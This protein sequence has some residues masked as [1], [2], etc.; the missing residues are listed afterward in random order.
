MSEKHIPEEYTDNRDNQ[1]KMVCSCGHS[2]PCPYFIPVEVKEALKKITPELDDMMVKEGLR[3]GKSLSEAE[4]WKK[5]SVDIGPAMK[6]WVK[7][8]EEKAKSNLSMP[9]DGQLYSFIDPDIHYHP[10][11]DEISLHGSFTADQLEA[12]AQ[13]MRKHSTDS[14][15]ES[16]PD[17]TQ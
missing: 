5:N 12:L 9:A 14:I 7:N 10:D 16:T 15:H 17:P 13:H 4:K 1:R 3:P 2:L 8:L 11:S 6:E